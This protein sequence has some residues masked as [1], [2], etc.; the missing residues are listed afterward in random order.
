MF[1]HSVQSHTDVDVHLPYVFRQVVISI[2]AVSNT[3]EYQYWII[4][5]VAVPPRA[6]G[7]LHLCDSAQS[8][9]TRGIHFSLH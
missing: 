9:E 3:Y 2:Y 5:Q 7:R 8:G 4:R 1:V 6:G